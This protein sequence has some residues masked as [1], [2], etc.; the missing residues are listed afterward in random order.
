MGSKLLEASVL[1][2][3]EAAA[4]RAGMAARECWTAAEEAVRREAAE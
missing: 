2:E 4:R 1:P 3:A